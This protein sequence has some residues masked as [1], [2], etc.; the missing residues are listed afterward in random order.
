MNIIFL[1]IDGV[2]NSGEYVH[3]PRY[4]KRRQLGFPDCDLDLM[5]IHHLNKICKETEAHIVVS[6]TWRE[7]DECVPA[8]K[9]NGVKAPIIGKTPTLH[10]AEATRGEEIQS[11][12]QGYE[13]ENYL[14]I[15]D[16][17]D[18]LPRQKENFLHIDRKQGLTEQDVTK[19]IN[20]FKD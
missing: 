12:I 6:S 2:L 17:S 18:M 8:L 7:M 19:A 15:D 14:I 1:D 10:R 9:R 13:I 20:H 11:Y 3:S 16:D 5:A 4:K